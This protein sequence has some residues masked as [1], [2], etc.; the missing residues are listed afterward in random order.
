MRVVISYNGEHTAH[1]RGNGVEIPYTY[2]DLCPLFIDKMASDASD[3]IDKYDRLRKYEKSAELLESIVIEYLVSKGMSERDLQNVD[4][5]S[6]EKGKITL[7]KDFNRTLLVRVP[8]D[9]NNYESQC[10]AWLKVLN[11]P[12]FWECKR[13]DPKVQVLKPTGEGSWNYQ[14]WRNIV[15]GTKILLEEK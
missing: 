5:S 15:T 9:Y 6:D 4:V 12:E 7:T 3:L 11:T 8:V 2:L 10:D 14:Y 1:M 13:L